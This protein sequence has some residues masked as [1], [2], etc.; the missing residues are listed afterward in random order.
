MTHKLLQICFGDGF[1]GS[2][3]MAI[4]SSELLMKKGIDITFLSTKDSL[5]EKRSR[6]KGLKVISVDSRK[7]FKELKEEVYDIFNELNP[8]S[9]I[10]HHSLERKTGISLR[11]KFGRK[12]INIGY[13]HNMS[14]SAPLVGALLYNYYFDYLIA[15]GTDVGKSL[16]RAGISKRKVK[17]IHYGIEVPENINEIS[18]EGIRKQYDLNGKTVI[19]L[20][21]WFHKQRKG[22]DILFKSFALLDDSYKL[23]IIGIPEDMKQKVLD[24]AY[25]FK[26]SPSKIIMPGYVE[27][28]FEYY[29]AMDIFVFPSRAEGFPLAPLEAGISGLPI[30]ASDIPG[31]NE[32]ITNDVNGILYPVEDYKAFSAAIKRLSHDKPLMKEFAVKAYNTVKEK[33]TSNTYSE[34][35]YKFISSLR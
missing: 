15:C 34:N 9:V 14:Q 35:L 2:A 1:A 12:F 25:E 19:G 18:G 11:R 33:Y 28:I 32:F 7:P 29:K 16:S 23:F 20:S 26:I 27:N 10:T 22:F 21:A 17:V 8:H 13:R 4:L 6:E 24:F 31:T 5:T 3:K 30:I